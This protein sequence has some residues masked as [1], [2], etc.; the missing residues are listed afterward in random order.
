MFKRIFH[1]R[2]ALPTPETEA[3]SS[4]E[5]GESEIVS[6]AEIH[7]ATESRHFFRRPIAVEFAPKSEKPVHASKNNVQE[8]NDEK[9]EKTTSPGYL[10]PP[11]LLLKKSRSFSFRLRP[12]SS[13]MF[14]VP[15]SK[16][17]HFADQVQVVEL[18]LSKKN[19]EYLKKEPEPP[20]E[21]NRS[22][23][24]VYT[25][26]TGDSS[27]SEE[28]MKRV[29]ESLEKIFNGE[30]QSAQVSETDEATD[31]SSSL[32]ENVADDSGSEANPEKHESMELLYGIYKHMCHTLELGPN[33][34]N[35]CT[36]FQLETDIHTGL[37]DLAANLQSTTDIMHTLR[38]KVEKHDTEAEQVLNTLNMQR[39]QID[40]LKKTNENLQDE[41]SKMSH[42]EDQADEKMQY[43]L[44]QAYL[45][46]DKIVAH[47]E[48]QIS[49]NHATIQN[50]RMEIENLKK[51]SAKTEEGLRSQAR[52]LMSRN[53]EVEAQLEEALSQIRESAKTRKVLEL[54][55]ER[56]KRDKTSIEDE[57]AA[58]VDKINQSHE[59][60][61][62]KLVLKFDNEYASLNKYHAQEKENLENEL[63]GEKF[64][65][66]N[67]EKLHLEKIA[68]LEVK[69]ESCENLKQNN[70]LLK[71]EVEYLENENKNLKSK[72]EEA[73]VAEAEKIKK[74]QAN[75]TTLRT[76]A[77]DLNAQV[78]KLSA[79]LQNSNCTI[80]KLE[81][82]IKN[83]NMKE[84]SKLKH[85]LQILNSNTFAVET[86]RK[87]IK[88]TF[89]VLTPIFHPDSTNQ[90][91]QAF[92]EYSQV[93]VFELT[94]HSMATLLCTFILT[95]IR[96]LV[97]EW[98]K[99]EKKLEAEVKNRL[100]Y[101]REVLQ[102]FSKIARNFNGGV[103]KCNSQICKQ[104]SSPAKRA[105]KRRCGLDI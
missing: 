14:K 67:W 53:S 13:S 63:N 59:D 19:E 80:S 92:Y 98:M 105:S 75:N 36:V 61:M 104:K 87:F 72:L 6:P 43:E 17:V 57:T 81:N 27:A 55:I 24:S 2:H 20:D 49:E 68:S 69:V 5:S 89:E 62:K 35:K 58:K 38:S 37:D 34:V 30:T 85:Y 45:E 84:K 29:G 90:F 18:G 47:F 74:T 31:E 50:Q 70:A 52:A 44:S 16:S 9:E 64:A 91:T 97:K 51:E 102:T 15:R 25:D 4:S 21:E 82:D 95:A 78:N 48:T 7:T 83:H 40:D 12:N 93:R 99:T 32:Q 60:E 26:D 71:R 41:L 66:A 73:Q 54:T 103:D 76:Q 39:S 77:V 86:L 1:S 101:Q 11:H 100:A 46:I 42:R 8:Q 28:T 88:A 23:S 3:S 22:S 65:N 79:Q 33:D 96:D 56:L 94:H 10:Q